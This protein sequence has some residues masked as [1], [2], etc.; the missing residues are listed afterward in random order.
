MFDQSMKSLE[1]EIIIKE[2]VMHRMARAMTEYAQR[3]GGKAVLSAED[4][5]RQEED[6]S[7][8]YYVK[9]VTPAL[10][11]KIHSHEWKWVDEK[12]EDKTP[13]KV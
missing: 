11:V 5:V 10:E 8:Y 6:G 9:G 4:Y 12:W 2:E 1:N 13:Y 7:L 3:Y